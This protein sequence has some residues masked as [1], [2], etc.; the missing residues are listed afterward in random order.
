MAGAS[1]VGIPGVW[2]Q[3][4]PL[5]NEAIEHLDASY[6]HS[7]WSDW[8]DH[9]HHTAKGPLEAAE[10]ILQLGDCAQSGVVPASSSRLG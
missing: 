10:F 7:G 9:C 8:R 6:A 1:R 5:S 4:S 3:P 2:I